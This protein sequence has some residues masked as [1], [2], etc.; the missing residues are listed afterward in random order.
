MAVHQYTET[1]EVVRFCFELIAFNYVQQHR[2]RSHEALESRVRREIN[3]EIR[4]S[5]L[6]HNQSPCFAGNTSTELMRRAI[7][8]EFDRFESLAKGF[9][10]GLEDELRS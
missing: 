4:V 5:T 8:K 10:V 2:Y 9:L 7:E 3:R 1:S 6:K